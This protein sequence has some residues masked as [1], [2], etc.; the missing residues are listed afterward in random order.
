MTKSYANKFDE[1]QSEA[2]NDITREFEEK[3]DGRFLLVVPT[4]GGKTITAVKSVNALYD[5]KI[6]DETDDRVMWVA[7]RDYL[8]SQAKDSFSTFEKWYPERNS[9]KNSVDFLM[10][11]EAPE[12][13]SDNPG[14]KLIVIDEAHHAAA[15]SYL[16]LFE[17]SDL[18][19]LGLTATPTRHDGKPLDFEYEAYSIGFPDLIERGVVLRPTI[20]RIDTGLEYDD[21][22]G[23][24]KEDLDKLDD[25]ARNQKIIDAIDANLDDYDKVVIYVG[26]VG[27]A[28]HLAKAIEQSDLKDHYESISYITGDGNSRGLPRKDFL[29]IEKSWKRSIIV[30]VDVL[31]EG[32]DDPT[33]NTIVMARP[34]RSKLVY[35]QAMGRSIRHDPDNAAKRSFVLEVVD[36]LPNI[37]YRI[38]NRW[39][40]AE[41]SDALEPA[42]EDRTYSNIEVL[43][44]TL[45]DIYDAFD[46]DEDDRETVVQ[47]TDERNR[48][49]LLL[50]KVYMGENK[51]RHIPLLINKHNRVKVSNFYNYLSARIP[52]YVKNKV[53]SSE[54]MR[55]LDT[56]FSEV[57]QNP[58]KQ[59][60][61][62]EAM[63]NSLHEGVEKKALRDWITFISFRHRKS[64]DA[65][66]D[67]IKQF[68]GDMINEEQIHEELLTRSYEAESKLVRF[69]LPLG[70]FIGRLFSAPEFEEIQSIIGQIENVK[71][72][73]LD[74]DH[75]GAC[76]T[77][78][79]DSKLPVEHSLANSLLLI[80]R[81]ETDYYREVPK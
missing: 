14:V 69:P 61:I 4:G 53:N 47:D 56:S 73:L 22:H 13:L 42:V 72:K 81:E 6:L 51:T 7:H 20:R 68:L 71:K 55:P 17:K 27:H 54:I 63:E 38:D 79:N 44:E 8:C 50:F 18:G 43:N 80:V 57:L 25:S 37:R 67:E 29:A 78:L 41:I 40:Y 46:V 31:T 75:R 33:V 12:F 62:L 36:G 48:Y 2:V 52:Y 24:T 74:Q 59:H 45:S 34:T 76:T 30:N 21:I 70:Q 1:F 65:L 16:P 28:K 77:I 64:E 23:F 26:S 11:D 3:P 58:K 9:Y 39:L 15:K 32:Y 10:R 49:S 19:I 5:R 35:M 66:S 60:L